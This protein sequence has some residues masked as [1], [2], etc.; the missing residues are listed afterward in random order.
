MN[1]IKTKSNN[2]NRTDL[3]SVLARIDEIT[4][5]ISDLKETYAS[6]WREDEVGR[7]LELKGRLIEVHSIKQSLEDIAFLEELEVLAKAS[8][9]PARDIADRMYAKAKERKVPESD[10]KSLL[11]YCGV[12]TEPQTEVAADGTVRTLQPWQ[13]PVNRG[14]ML[15]RGR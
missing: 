13:V 1:S 15:G 7:A 5:E 14:A 10:I 9:M 2:V 3:S 6:Y 12:S 11:L 4:T 8:I